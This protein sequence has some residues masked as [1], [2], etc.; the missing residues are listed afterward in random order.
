MFDYDDLIITK[1]KESEKKQQQEVSGAAAGEGGSLHLRGGADSPLQDSMISSSMVAQQQLLQNKQN[2]EISRGQVVGGL[3]SNTPPVLASVSPLPVVIGVDNIGLVTMQNESRTGSFDPMMI[4]N[5][6][7]FNVG[8]QQVHMQQQQQCNVRMMG[9]GGA[10]LQQ[11][12]NPINFQHQH[13]RPLA[14]QG[15]FLDF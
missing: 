3:Q 15:I 8:Q 6:Q 2:D 1:P 10:Q 12:F 9:A 14:P 5:K 11:G 4:M 7:Q 13:V